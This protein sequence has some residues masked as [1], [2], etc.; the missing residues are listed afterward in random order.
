MAPHA[1][2]QEP[3]GAH[4][5]RWMLLDVASVGMIHQFSSDSDWY[6]E[7]V[8]DIQ[9]FRI[10]RHAGARGHHGI[11]IAAHPEIRLGQHGV[12][13]CVNRIQRGMIFRRGVGAGI[14]VRNLIPKWICENRYRQNR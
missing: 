11:R 14:Y 10:E 4:C 5:M 9:H 8:P 1:E 12:F 7:A 6:G 3:D 2:A 13:V